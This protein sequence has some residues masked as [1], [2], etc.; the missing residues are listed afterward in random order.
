MKEKHKGEFGLSR[1]G[2]DESGE[3]SPSRR[4]LGDDLIDKSEYEES[5]EDQSANGDEKNG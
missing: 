1:Q 5:E 2:T 3:E 4:H